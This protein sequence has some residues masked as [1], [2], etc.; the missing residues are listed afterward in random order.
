MAKADKAPA[1]GTGGGLKTILVLAVVGL[2]SAGAGFAVPRFLLGG[3]GKHE[4][5]GGDARPALTNK[6]ALVPFGDVVVNIHDERLSRYLRVKII[7]VVDEAHEKPVKEILD[8]KK[9]I[10][11]NWLISYLC[12]RT[13]EE[14]KGA[15]GVNR[16]RREIQEQ[17]NLLLWPD[18]AEKIRDVLF[19]EFVVQ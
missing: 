2:V 19:D 17:F 12:D 15:G 11:K 10:L 16:L 13:L 8:K 18:G 6:L 5:K 14:V 1:A 4:A 3:T 9:A 7:L